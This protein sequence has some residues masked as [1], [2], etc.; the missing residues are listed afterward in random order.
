MPKKWGNV[1]GVYI[2]GEGNKE[3]PTLGEALFDRKA[4]LGKKT[5]STEETALEAARAQLRGREKDLEEDKKIWSGATKEEL[6]KIKRDAQ[7][8]R[9]IE[10]Q[11]NRGKFDPDSLQR[12]NQKEN[13]LSEKERQQ[14][15]KNAEEAGEKISAEL[16]SIPVEGTLEFLRKA[17][18]DREKERLADAARGADNPFSLPD[19]EDSKEIVRL[20]KEYTNLDNK[21]ASAGND[22]QDVL[23][24]WQEWAADFEEVNRA[25]KETR[26]KVRDEDPEEL[27]LRRMALWLFKVDHE[28]SAREYINV[29]G[30]LRERH[31][32][33]LHGRAE[34]EL[35]PTPVSAPT[36]ATKREQAKEKEKKEQGFRPEQIDHDIFATWRGR[37]EKEDVLPLLKKTILRFNEVLAQNERSA[38]EWV[39]QARL[40]Y[41]EDIDPNFENR[42]FF[43][44][45]VPTIRAHRA[46][47]LHTFLQT[48]ES[49]LKENKPIPEDTTYY[50]N[51]STENAKPS[52]LPDAASQKE[53]EPD[54]ALETGGFND[55]VGKFVEELSEDQ[56]N[57]LRDTQWYSALSVKKSEARVQGAVE[58]FFDDLKSNIGDLSSERKHI[59]ALFWFD[60][61]IAPSKRPVASEMSRRLKSLPVS[62]VVKSPVLP[63]AKDIPAIDN[64]PPPVADIIPTETTPKIISWTGAMASEKKEDHLIN[65][66]ASYFSAEGGIIGVFD[67]MGGHQDGDR[68]SRIGR[69]VLQ[70]SAEDLN[71]VST[72]AEV[73]GKLREIF[74]RM[75]DDV[76]T[77][78]PEKS[79]R[80]MPGTCATVAKI[81]QEGGKHIAVVGNIG[82][83][84]AYVFRAGARTLEQITKDDDYLG[85]VEESVPLFQYVSSIQKIL[86]EVTDA[87]QL[88]DQA[89]FTGAFPDVPI[90]QEPNGLALLNARLSDDLGVI[91]ILELFHRRNN[92]SKNIGGGNFEPAIVQTE[93]AHG[94]ILFCTSDGIHD[95]LTNSEIQSIIQKNI[96]KAPGQLARILLDRA[97][98]VVDERTLRSK[99]DDM[100]VVVLKG[101]N[102][103]VVHDARTAASEADSTAPTES[104]H[105][106]LGIESTQT[107]KNFLS[108]YTMARDSDPA[109]RALISGWRESATTARIETER[110]IVLR[111]ILAQLDAGELESSSGEATAEKRVGDRLYERLH[112]LKPDMAAQKEIQRGDE[113]NVRIIGTDTFKK[114]EIEEYDGKKIEIRFV[115]VKGVIPRKL[116]MDRVYKIRIL[117]TNK[118]KDKKIG[119]GKHYWHEAEVIGPSLEEGEEF[120]AQFE[121]PMK[122]GVYRTF[123]PDGL[124]VFVSGSEDLD[125]TK[126]HTV[127]ISRVVDFSQPDS[128]RHHAGYLKEERSSLSASPSGEAEPIGL[129]WG[130]LTPEKKTEFAADRELFMRMFPEGI[131]TRGIFERDYESGEAKLLPQ[132]NLD[133]ESCIFLLQRFFDLPADYISKTGFVRP[134]EFKPNA[135]NVDTGFET[136]GFQVK[137]FTKDELAAQGL[138]APEVA[139]QKE[140][141][142]G[143]AHVVIVQDHGPDANRTMSAF[144]LLYD[145][146][147]DRYGEDAIPP[148]DREPMKNFVKFVTHIDNFTAPTADFDWKK[149]WWES[150][151]IPFMLA[152]AKQNFLNVRDLYRFFKEHPFEDA[153]KRPSEWAVDAPPKLRNVYY[154][155][156]AEA[157][158]LGKYGFG[159]MGRIRKDGRQEPIMTEQYKLIEKGDRYFEYL[160]HNEPEFI[161]ESPTYGKILVVLDGDHV[162]GRLSAAMACGIDG[163]L[164]WRPGEKSFWFN[165]APQKDPADYSTPQIPH[166]LAED[167][168]GVWVRGSIVMQPD[169]KKQDLKAGLNLGA[170]L[171]KI[172][173]PLDALQGRLKKRVE[174]ENDGE[175]P[176]ETLPA[177]ADFLALKAELKKAISETGSLLVSSANPNDKTVN[178]EKEEFFLRSLIRPEKFAN[179]SINIWVMA[180][181]E[182]FNDQIMNTFM[183]WMDGY[184][185]VASADAA[186]GTITESNGTVSDKA[187]FVERYED[188]PQM[189]RRASRGI[190]KGAVERWFDEVLA[191]KRISASSAVEPARAEPL[192]ATPESAGTARTPEIASATPAPAETPTGAAAIHQA[193]QARAAALDS[194]LQAEAQAQQATEDAHVVEA[195]VELERVTDRL[196]RARATKEQYEGVLKGFAGFITGKG[197]Q[198]EAEYDSALHEYEETIKR[199]LG[200]MLIDGLEWR[201]K[202]VEKMIEARLAAS[203]KKGLGTRAVELWKS[204]GE[205]SLYNYINK[206]DGWKDKRGLLWGS[207]KVLAKA[208]NLRTATALGLFGG[209][210]IAGATAV[211]WSA[212]GAGA[213]LS[214]LGSGIGFNEWTRHGYEIGRT[215][216]SSPRAQ[217][218]KDQAEAEAHYQAEYAS[219]GRLKKLWRGLSGQ[220]LSA[221]G[222]AAKAVWLEKLGKGNAT[223]KRRAIAERLFAFEADALLYGKKD[224]LSDASYQ[225]LVA[226]Y[227]EAVA[228]EELAVGGALEGYF[229]AQGKGFVEKLDDTIGG[230]KSALR[231]RKVFS[232]FAGA[233][234]GLASLAN[235]DVRSYVRG[236]GSE[237]KPPAG[238][239][240]AEH[241]PV[242]QAPSPRVES[243]PEAEVPT[244]APSAP[245]ETIPAPQE[246]SAPSEVPQVEAPEATPVP[247][248][249]PTPAP[250][251][252]PV[253]APS[254]HELPPSSTPPT[255]APRAPSA[256]PVEAPR[257]ARSPF[258]DLVRQAQGER[259]W[260]GVRKIAGGE[261]AHVVPQ[262]GHRAVIQA[263][264]ELLKEDP[265]QFGM[266]IHPSNALIEAKATAIARKLGFMGHGYSLGFKFDAEH[267]IGLF[268]K[269]GQISV[270]AENEETL[271]RL[272]GA[273]KRGGGVMKPDAARPY[274]D[275]A[276]PKIRAH[277]IFVEGQSGQPVDATHVRVSTGVGVPQHGAS[278][279]GDIGASRGVGAGVHG[280]ATRVAGT[281]VSSDMAVPTGETVGAQ[282][283]SAGTTPGAGAG[284][285]VG[286]AGRGELG[287]GGSGAGSRADGGGRVSSTE[288]VPGVE[289]KP[290]FVRS[291][292]GIK[293]EASGAYKPQELERIKEL[294]EEL[295][296]QKTFVETQLAL[297][298]SSEAG[299]KL[300][301]VFK[302][303]TSA[304][305]DLLE[306]FRYKILGGKASVKELEALVNGSPLKEVAIPVSESVGEAVGVGFANA[307]TRIVSDP[308]KHILSVW[309]GTTRSVVTLNLPDAFEVD[310]RF[311]RGELLAVKLLTPG[312]NK[313][314]GV[315]KFVK[316]VLH[317]VF[318]EGAEKKDLLWGDFIKKY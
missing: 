29:R 97:Q 231:R 21:L 89:A 126:P 69:Y 90:A 221:E 148:G 245:E 77:A 57:E 165:V 266:G 92:I 102:A 63:K 81:V 142:A 2:G 130:D 272:M 209:G 166:E 252:P 135:L 161:V 297:L 111:H 313:F 22:Q 290:V 299:K 242:E 305:K 47:A 178:G 198:A 170:F 273:V 38:R 96:G 157:D 105:G 226:A 195:R 310:S 41:K 196:A 219:V 62:E 42:E 115:G 277:A 267:P 147:I 34:N 201:T 37:M 188:L 215:S 144:K 85:K 204:A 79:G 100:T 184:M 61:K 238:I 234:L 295:Q 55:R 154:D 72:V 244:E 27:K 265:K 268:A 182:W 235:F 227:K 68:A 99:S 288:V 232:A 82:D 120:E 291:I 56:R 123:A 278:R 20:E 131:V 98:A 106:S 248:V 75:Q 133:A 26:E 164:E 259:A 218:F 110:V 129:K 51:K 274:V 271:H 15:E 65:E 171:E 10:E 286:G 74:Q 16:R 136:T 127:V 132:G 80:E 214:A 104:E 138:A 180:V 125:I 109:R 39:A 301:E 117:E 236:L 177:D 307:S 121:T 45:K 191:G 59:N 199:E 239:V 64:L 174:E 40:L 179:Y 312:G 217:V 70:E 162:P 254:G 119:G 228:E 58:D 233:T 32:P 145:A 237:G 220:G 223:E 285:G 230:E 143:G 114:A 153:F 87:E 139:D 251:A 146:L 160:Q 281:G 25:L 167:V 264:K 88:R 12:S 19:N 140:E 257:T 303:K 192:V 152:L 78:F 208:A 116:E 207:L 260:T 261:Y 298:Q 1:G 30:V 262:K 187:Q 103:T 292:G 318:K 296:R 247:P 316:G 31:R 23:R 66:D 67:G 159:T 224:L 3:E 246:P 173:V 124:A 289:A 168:G 256:P 134:G 183:N 108:Q 302:P 24:V 48:A 46:W 216:G 294:A 17:Q 197:S 258:E 76:K 50:A 150:D 282:G 206:K 4:K 43:G 315:F 83:S 229:E 155:F 13:A 112:S 202:L 213:G 73:R 93:I 33:T 163:M 284:T 205:V 270:V 185:S 53:A 71:S 11:K 54:A 101:E 210:W 212:A 91:S 94:D 222:A 9:L 151:K 225:K 211:G 309:N 107:Y 193:Q 190:W 137:W 287:G 141:D 250:S 203:E 36:P 311:V 194:A 60:H 28:K 253:E 18:E 86:S 243:A 175:K 314:D 84:R 6:K 306:T 189:Y 308:E 169:W 7:S 263:V 200:S 156:R 128:K 293:F 304:F 275:Q 118:S 280:D 113:F 255:E 249:E 14:R 95:N 240:P 149:A 283:G 5:K 300:V 49:A 241:A 279:V 44:G 122:P 181:H 176:W 52:S 276:F 317:V 158:A 35:P 8:V 172:G 186:A 269:D